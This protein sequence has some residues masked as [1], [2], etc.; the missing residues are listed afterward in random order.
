V[1]KPEELT[2]N[3]VYD[4]CA[5][6][7][8]Y[9]IDRIFSSRFKYNLVRKFVNRSDVILD[10]GCGNGIHMQV[11][12]QHCRAVKGIDIN[13]KMLALA[14]QKL[15]EKQLAN[16]EVD[17]QSASELK[18][19]D[20][21][22]D[23]V[24]SFSTLLLV[25]DIF[26]AIGEL[27]R[28]LRE[29]GIAILDITGKYNLSQLHWRRFY[30][31]QGHFGL[32]AFSHG[33]MVNV[34][35]SFGLRIEEQH[36]LGFTDQWKYLPGGRLLGFAERLFHGNEDDDLDYRISNWPLFFPLANRWYVVCRKESI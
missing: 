14:K 35:A 18:F 17:L 6:T 31:K 16:T 32:H 34:L 29:G 2:S 13:E 23:L 30:R 36:A 24:Y 28:V 9:E 3:N 19:S 1:I 15:D 22:F 27:A 25:P 8:G 12:A 10:V 5:A 4:R 33:T 11:L 20:D 21:A 7:Y 26:G